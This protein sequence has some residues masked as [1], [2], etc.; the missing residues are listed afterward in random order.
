MSITP[1][2]NN[3]FSLSNPLPPNQGNDD[4]T[5]NIN[6]GLSTIVCPLSSRLVLEPVIDL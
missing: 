5:E 3:S 1:P 6:V 4:L 2:R